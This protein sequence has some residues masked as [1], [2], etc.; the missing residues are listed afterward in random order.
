MPAATSAPPL[1][2]PPN[3]WTRNW[4]WFVPVVCVTT[5]ALFLGFVTLIISIVFGAIKSSDAYK[6]PVTIAKADSRVIAAIGSPVED[7]FFVTGKIHVSGSSGTANLA[8]PLKGPKGRGTLYVV[9]SKEAGVWQFR[10]LV[11]QPKGS[12]SRIDLNQTVSQ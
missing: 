12:P 5:I 9:A 6:T 8:I 4:K 3:W 7:G 10:T 2:R 1:L 11:F